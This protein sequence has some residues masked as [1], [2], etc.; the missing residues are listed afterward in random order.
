MSKSQ[1][2]YSVTKHRLSHKKTN[3]SQRKWCD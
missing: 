3:Q 2:R 1:K